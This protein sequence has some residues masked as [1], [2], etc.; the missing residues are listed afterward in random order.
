ADDEVQPSLF[1]PISAVPL[2]GGEVPEWELEEDGTGELP[3][4][5]D[6]TV[7]LPA[8]PPRGGAGVGAHPG[9]GGH[10][11]PTRREHKERLREANA[12]KAR[13]IARH[14]GMTHAKVNAE[15]NRVAGLNRISEG[16][17][18]Q[19]ERRLQKADAWLRQ[20]SARRV[21]G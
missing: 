1:S 14:T 15:L 21:P 20:A 4:D 10:A 7:T 8:I 5:A 6:L 2:D 17:V 13:L 9:D 16:T 12:A 11:G 19:L 18:D 3:D